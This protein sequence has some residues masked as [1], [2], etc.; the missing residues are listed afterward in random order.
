MEETGVSGR[1]VHEEL[2]VVRSQ[3]FQV[4]CFVTV[5]AVV[6]VHQDEGLLGSHAFMAGE[7]YE[8]IGYRGKGWTVRM[9]LRSQNIRLVVSH[10]VREDVSH[11]RRSAYGRREPALNAIK[12]IQKRFWIGCAANLSIAMGTS[13]GSSLQHT[14]VA[15]PRLLHVPIEQAGLQYPAPTHEV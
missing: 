12:G 5:E 15:R 8:E 13:A 14:T 3:A 2:A 10:S 1:D 7:R 9:A 6:D 11:W 4:R